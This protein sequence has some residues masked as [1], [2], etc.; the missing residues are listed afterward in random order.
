MLRVAS[1]LRPQAG[2]LDKRSNWEIRCSMKSEKM[3]YKTLSREEF[4]AIVTGE[5]T[6]YALWLER[7][8][9]EVI[10]SHFMGRSKKRVDFERLFLRRDGLTFQDKID[11]V[12]AMLPMFRNQSASSDLKRLLM[13][14]E[15]FKAFRLSLI[16]I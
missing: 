12:R 3:D 1:R 4:D 2:G 14:V 7:E 6:H 16:H 10:G 15:E 8:M 5:L 9:T 13:Q 11:I